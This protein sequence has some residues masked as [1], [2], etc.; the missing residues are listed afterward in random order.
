MSWFR[1]MFMTLLITVAGITAAMAQTTT[2][3]AAPVAVT[4]AP[5]KGSALWNGYP[6]DKSGFYYGLNT[7]G[8]MGSVQAS[9]SGSTGGTAAATDG[10]LGGTLGWVWSNGTYFYAIEAMANWTNVSGT[11]GGASLTGSAS[12]EQ[13]F[14][15]G[16]PLAQVM[17]LPGFNTLLANNSTVP[18]FPALGNGQVASNIHPYV[19]VG[20]V[21]DDI[22]LNVGLNRN[23]AWEAAFD[24]GTGMMGQ[25]ANGLAIDSWI[26]VKLQ[27]SAVCFGGGVV[28]ANQGPWYHVGLG[29]YF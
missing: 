1:T 12:F 27:Q 5:V 11:V 24:V 22:S 3:P 9:G 28:C 18:P 8:G 2:V 4:K 21:E 23:R 10:S 25:L 17:S 26:G 6:Y 16:T 15:I 20:V 19:Y 13:R 14:K 7:Q 29:L